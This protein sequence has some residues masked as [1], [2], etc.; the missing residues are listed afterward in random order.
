MSDWT[1]KA[2]PHSSYLQVMKF[3]YKDKNRL[4]L[5]GWRKVYHAYT[6]E[7]SGV[8][9]WRTEKSKLQSKEYYQG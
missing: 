9:L 3:K 4:K 2:R 5:N 7:K 1:K 6:N 8:A